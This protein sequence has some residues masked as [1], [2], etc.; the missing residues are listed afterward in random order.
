MI[1]ILISSLRGLD[2]KEKGRVPKAALAK[3][4]FLINLLRVKSVIGF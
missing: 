2:R 4:D 1:P 3:V